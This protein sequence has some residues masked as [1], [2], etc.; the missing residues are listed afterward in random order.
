M[1]EANSDISRKKMRHRFQAFFCLVIHLGFLFLDGLIMDIF[2]VGHQLIDSS[3]WCEF[4]DAIG[5]G[6]D[7]LMVVA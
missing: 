3:V 5:Y 7:K 6:L 1:P 4:N 2:I